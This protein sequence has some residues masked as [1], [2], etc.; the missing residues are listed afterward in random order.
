[1]NQE[2]RL[3]VVAIILENPTEIQERVNHIISE[4]GE[5]ICGRMG[6]PDHPR[7]LATIALIV[8]GT[9]DQINTLT[10]KLGNLPGVSARAT[11]AKKS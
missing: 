5:I 1:M 4:A 6:I 11:M 3:A 2:K 8:E 10:G 7:N 9:E